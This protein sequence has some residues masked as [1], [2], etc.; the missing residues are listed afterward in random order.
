[1]NLERGRRFEEWQLMAQLG[2]FQESTTSHGSQVAASRY[3]RRIAVANWKTLYVWA[4]E[5]YE[6]LNAESEFYPSSWESPSGTLVL[7]PVILQLGAVCSQLGFTENEDEL[8]AITDRGVMYVNLNS[9]GS[10]KREEVNGHEII[11]GEN[12]DH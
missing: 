8:I 1:M 4:L 6:V 10:G 11:L 5:P 2:G 3:G 12:K 7:R 9:K